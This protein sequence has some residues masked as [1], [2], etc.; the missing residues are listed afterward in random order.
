MPIPEDNPLTRDKVA[1]GRR[2]FSDPILSYDRHLACIDCHQPERSFT[3]G[4]PVGVGIFGRTGTR[5]VPT[6]V[7][8]GYG[9]KFFWDGRIAR[10]EAQ[11]LEPIRARTEMDRPLG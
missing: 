3:D 8:R 2:L 7:N 1:L 6:L 4:R 9:S 5:H 10:R 11:V